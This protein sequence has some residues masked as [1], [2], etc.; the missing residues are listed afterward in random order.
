[1]EVLFKVLEDYVVDNR[2]DVGFWVW[3]VVMDVLKWCLFFFC[4]EI[5]VDQRKVEFKYFFGGIECFFGGIE[6][7]FG[8]L[9]ISGLIIEWFNIFFDKEIVVKVVG[10]LVKQVVEKIDCVRD[11]VGCML[12][13]LLYSD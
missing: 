4:L 13:Q 6:C 8:E 7:F 10:G 2:G 9:E 12:Q 1:M 11:V 3:E 5:K